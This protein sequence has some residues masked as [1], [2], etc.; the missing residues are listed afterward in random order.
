MADLRPHKQYDFN[1]W[2]EEK[3]RR[4]AERAHDRA[5]ERTTDLND[6]AVTDA[7]ETIKALDA[8]VST[9]Y[10]R[11]WNHPFIKYSVVMRRWMRLA[12]TF[13]WSALI[14]SIG[15]LVCFVAGV[16]SVRNAIVHFG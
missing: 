3:R 4:D 12:L 6:K 7:R 8:S 10:E 9:A 16:W 14:I 5:A 11:T 2:L 15:S 1:I 13:H